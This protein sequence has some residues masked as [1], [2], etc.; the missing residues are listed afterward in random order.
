MK[1][2]ISHK[3]E[4]EL[5]DALVAKITEELKTMKNPKI[6]WDYRDELSEK[7]IAKILKSPDGLFEVENE[8]FEMNS[9]HIYDLEIDHLKEAL[10]S[11]KEELCEELGIEDDELDLEEIARELRDEFLDYISVDYNIEDLIK[12]TGPINCRVELFSNYDC[13]NSHW[14][15]AIQGGGY[16]YEETYFGAMIDALNLNPGKMKEALEKREITIY[17]E[18]PDLKERNG[19]EFVDYDKF[20][21]ELENSTCGANLLTIV[22]KVDLSM[23]IEKGGL[24]S[25]FTIPKGN[26]VGLF[27]S[28]QGGG[29]TIECP[30]LRDI[31]IDTEK[32]GE[33]E[34]DHWSKILPDDDRDNGYGINDVYGVHSDFFGNEISLVPSE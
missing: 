17:G 21:R 25:K 7:Q 33:T 31:V 29:S 2:N 19:E 13:I 22:C 28:F 24:P 5:S 23:I 32:R 11:F 1:I 15:E 8:M 26:N 4:A 34:Y 30:L 12:N 20:V 6:Y 3:E 14:F 18:W 10:D 27:S 16:S 9:D